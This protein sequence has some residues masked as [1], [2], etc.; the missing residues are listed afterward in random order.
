M[1]GMVPMFENL[2]QDNLPRVEKTMLQ[3][4]IEELMKQK[5]VTLVD[6]Q[7]VTQIPWSTLHYWATGGSPIADKSK[8]ILKLARYFGVS[9]E[10]LLFGKDT[11]PQESKTA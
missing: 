11:D 6:V 2:P 7:E 1:K 3:C 9:L 8:R 10:E 5:G 4:Q